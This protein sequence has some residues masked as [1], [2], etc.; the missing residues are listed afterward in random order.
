ME[1]IV[2]VI[3]V[4]ALFAFL[5]SELCT[6]IRRRKVFKFRNYICLMSLSYNNRRISDGTR[7]RGDALVWFHGKYSMLDMLYSSK[8]M[9][10][11]YWYTKEELDEIKR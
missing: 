6:E 5:I 11:D 10:L 2:V 4:I 7:G 1:L 9:L 3:V 8:P